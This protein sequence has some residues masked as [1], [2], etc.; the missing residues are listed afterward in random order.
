MA[1]KKAEPTFELMIDGQLH[2][3]HT[4]IVPPVG[5]KVVLKDDF[6]NRTHI[7]ITQHEWRYEMLTESFILTVHAKSMKRRG[8]TRSLKGVLKQTN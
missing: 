7:E 5:T 8:K 6:Q 2:L 3:P 1:K 4:A